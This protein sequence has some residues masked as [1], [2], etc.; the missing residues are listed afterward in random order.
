MPHLT[1]RI[2]SIMNRVEQAIG[3][4]GTHLSTT[5]FA[6]PPFP[7]SDFNSM[8]VLYQLNWTFPCWCF[9]QKFPNVLSREENMSLHICVRRISLCNWK[10]LFIHPCFNTWHLLWTCKPLESK[11]PSR[12]L[13]SLRLDFVFISCGEI[14]C[15]SIWF[16]TQAGGSPAGVAE[17]C[18]SSNSRWHRPCVQVW[19]ISWLSFMMS[20]D[21]A[22]KCR[23]WSTVCS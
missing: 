3:P 8:P 5:W 4:E 10:Q 9:L 1:L 20:A 16:I 6:K 18:F 13:V 19:S 21:R 22:I 7:K 12:F 2:F 17:I 14:T 23:W 15:F 11:L